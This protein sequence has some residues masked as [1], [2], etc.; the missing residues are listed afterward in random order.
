[1]PKEVTDA[2]LE[3]TQAALREG[4]ER[5]KTLVHDYEQL[6]RPQPAE[7]DEPAAPN[8]VR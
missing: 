2:Q 7:I 1:M 6:V 8:P 4:I 5:A 3:E